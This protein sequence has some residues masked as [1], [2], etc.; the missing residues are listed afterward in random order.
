V[1]ARLPYT[2]VS[3]RFWSDHNASPSDPP[4][5]EASRKP[6]A[7]AGESCVTS[8]VMLSTPCAIEPHTKMP[9]IGAIEAIADAIDSITMASKIGSIDWRPHRETWA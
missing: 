3:P 9:R 4:F 1:K 8:A 7:E 5:E 2:H 6:R